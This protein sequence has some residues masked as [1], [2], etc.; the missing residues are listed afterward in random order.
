MV[1]Y[2]DYIL[3][4]QW[5]IIK[6]DLIAIRGSK[7]ERCGCVRPANKLHIHHL[8]YERLGNEEPSDLEILCPLCHMHEHGIKPKKD[9]KKS[10]PKKSHKKP[11][12]QKTKSKSQKKVK[13]KPN[14]KTPIDL[15][16]EKMRAKFG[17]GNI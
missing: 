11:P 12:R 13:K 16:W 7:C 1:N 8:T 5:S 6:I 2:K 14:N 4:E 3:S 9:Q 15:K 17:F 10:K